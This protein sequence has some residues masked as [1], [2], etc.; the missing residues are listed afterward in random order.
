MLSWGSGRHTLHTRTVFLGLCSGWG[1]FTN[2]S[3]PNC[4]EPEEDGGSCGWPYTL[5]LG[6]PDATALAQQF[7][8][9]QGKRPRL[10]PAI[11][12]HPGLWEVPPTT[13]IVPPDAA[14]Q[15]YGFRVGLR[16]RV[17]ARSPMPYPSL[18]E[19][20]TGKLIG[21]D[22]TLL[23]D[24]GLSGDEMRAIL[25]YTLDQHLAGN[26]APFVFVAHSHLYAYSN[27]EDN[28]DTPTD[29]ARQARWK[30]LTE[31]LDYALS[32]P[33]VRIVSVRQ[34]VAWMQRFATQ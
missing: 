23:I 25:E 13:L 27:P 28:P 16:Q 34:I 3:L 9:Q 8:Q 24:A 26:H 33:Q 29:A 7:G 17:A 6:S 32:R 1:F 21:M 30:G 14:A 12:K 19:P 4:F 22:Y 2:S 31:F 10:F 11:G 5:D 18:Y 20:S 15:N